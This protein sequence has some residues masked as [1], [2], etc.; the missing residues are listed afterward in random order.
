MGNTKSLHVQNTREN[1][2]TNDGGRKQLWKTICAYFHANSKQRWETDIT[3]L[4][5]VVGGRKCR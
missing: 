3:L 5:G 4:M 1:N 2:Y